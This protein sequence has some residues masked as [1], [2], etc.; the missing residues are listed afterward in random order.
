[1][2]NITHSTEKHNMLM[3]VCTTFQVFT[4]RHAQCFHTVVHH[5]VSKI[6]AFLKTL[7]YINEM[8]WT[9]SA[10]LFCFFPNVTCW[11]HLI[12][13]CAEVCSFKMM[14]FS[15]AY[16]FKR[17]H[18]GH[19]KNIC[20]SSVGIQDQ[21]FPVVTSLVSLSRR[22]NVMCIRKNKTKTKLIVSLCICIRK[23]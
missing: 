7:I 4:A 10:P 6:L 5:T 19:T 20:H 3:I 16:R 8:W 22:W 1:M 12:I 18:Q 15:F 21:L 11:T 17:G 9:N 13:V 14:G 23:H 2:K